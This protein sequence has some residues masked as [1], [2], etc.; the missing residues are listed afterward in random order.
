MIGWE[1]T[2]VHEIAHLLDC[3][4]ERQA[5]APYGATSRTA[6]A[7]PWSATQCSVGCEEAQAGRHQVLGSSVAQPPALP[8]TPA[9]A[10]G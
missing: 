8:P 5:V 10:G 2:F 4:R 1:H 6:T 7:P 3:D 9:D